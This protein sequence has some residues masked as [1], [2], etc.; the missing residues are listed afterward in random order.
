MFIDIL[1]KYKDDKKLVVVNGIEAD[2][3]KD[4]KTGEYKGG[5]YIKEVYPD[6]IVL[7]IHNVKA[8]SKTDKLTETEELIHIPLHAIESVSEGSRDTTQKQL[9]ILGE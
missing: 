2:K 6:Y 4:K 1:T 5:T 9:N 7:R 3:V 8:E